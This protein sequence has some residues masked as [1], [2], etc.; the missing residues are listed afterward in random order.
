MKRFLFLGLAILLAAPLRAA[1]DSPAPIAPLLPANSASVVKWS[2]EVPEPRVAAGGLADEAHQTAFVVRAKNVKGAPMAGVPVELPRI[3]NDKKEL[4]DKNLESPEII[5]P[6]VAWS[7]P[8]KTLLTDA[9]GEARGVFT[10]GGKTGQ[11]FLYGPGETKAK[12][13]QVFNDEA[14]PWKDTKVFGIGFPRR[15]K[16]RL[17][18]GEKSLPICG[19]HLKLVLDTITLEARRFTGEFDENGA[20]KTESPFDLKFRKP[21]TDASPGEKARWEIILKWV[22]FEEVT[23][24]SPGLY[25][26]TCDVIPFDDEYPILDGVQISAINAIGVPMQDKSVFEDY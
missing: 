2:L 5:M 13:E 3:W 12:I 26:A 19:H 8:I 22:Q 24:I 11:L 6:R 17:L 10:S 1:N 4:G 25:E 20:P 7:S 18:R 16:M 21:E 23:E 14:E 9:R 15:Y